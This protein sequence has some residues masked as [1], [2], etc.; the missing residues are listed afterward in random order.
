MTIYERLDD[1]TRQA[2]GAKP[3]HRPKRKVNTNY[4]EREWR[5]LMNMNRDIYT[6][7]NGRVKRR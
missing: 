7:K 5:E 1:D 4:S 3:V 2:L 6:R